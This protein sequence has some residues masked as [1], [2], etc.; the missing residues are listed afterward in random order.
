MP[1]PVR[2]TI[3]QCSLT[4]LLVA[5]CSSSS[6]KTAPKQADSGAS[7]GTDGSPGGGS[8]TGPPDASDATLAPDT[9]PPA[10]ASGDAPVSNPGSDGGP[11]AGS[12]GA[13][14]QAAAVGY[15]VSTFSSTFAKSGFDLADTHAS[16]FEWYLGQYFG[17]AD[18]LASALTFNA[19]GTV[20][21]NAGGNLGS[22]APV[23]TSTSGFV[24]TAFGGGAYLEA[25]FKFDPADV[26]NNPDTSAWP[27][28]WG[29]SLEHCAGWSLNQTLDPWPGQAT[30]YAHF[31]E[32]DFFEYDIWNFAPHY[33]YA[34]TMHDW[35]GEYPTC[36][37]SSSSFCNVSN[38]PNDGTSFSNFVVTTPSTTDFTQYHAFGF[39]WVPATATTQGYGQYY[40]D[41]QAVNDRVTWS[42]LSSTDS[43]PPGTAPW[44][45]GILDQQH[46][47]LNIDTGVG[48]PMTLQS[49]HVWQASAASNLHY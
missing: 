41:G 42:L 27:S 29:F 48:E 35:Y 46:L 23:R 31:I 12:G 33:E 30:G 44:T 4:L 18:T 5:G 37:P 24:G 14:P 26:I 39:L 6:G 10:D 49:V 17:Y 8:E 13:P 34:G 19:D 16:G 47:T 21:L 40:F 28:W 22:T 32:T 45:F 7:A 38:A 25:T 43:P 2:C 1:K 9:E 36:D 11:D 15:T 3:A 20:T